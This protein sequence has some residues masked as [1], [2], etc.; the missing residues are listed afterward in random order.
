M[1]VITTLKYNALKYTMA[2]LLGMMAF[3]AGS[4]AMA[5]GGYSCL[6]TDKS[7]IEFHATV[8]RTII[9]N[10]VGVIF[11]ADKK[12]YTTNGE[13]A[14][15]MLAQSWIDKNQAMFDLVIA[16]T[17]EPVVAV[18]A[19]QTNTDFSKGTLTYQGVTHPVTCEFE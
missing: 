14:P 3:C 9:P 1:K 8:S 5:T 17:Q 13:N 4:P 2:P 19:R 16:E 7:G 12:E 18:R 6:A 11:I 15:W 10:V